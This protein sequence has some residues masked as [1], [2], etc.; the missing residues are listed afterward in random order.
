MGPVNV[1]LARRAWGRVLRT[2]PRLAAFVGRWLLRIG[3]PIA[4]AAALLTLFPYHAS[5]GGVQF[6]V[7]GSLIVNPG[8]SAD[9]TVGNW[10]F[11]QVDFLPVG[12]HVQ[13]VDL[14]L[15]TMSSAASADPAAYAEQLRHELS[16][17]VPAITAWLVAELMLGILLGL[18]AAAA[19]NLAIRQWRGQPR[20]AHELR[21]R[22]RQL[23]V[24]GLVLLVLVGVGAATYNPHWA[25]RS[26]LSG[27][28]AALQLFPGDLR[29]YYAQRTKALDVFDAIAV[30][31]SNLEQRVAIGTTP[32]TAYSIMFISDMH[33]ASNYPMVMRYAESFDVD[34]IINT[35]D[36]SEF[37]T[38]A[39]LTTAY[40]NQLRAVTAETPMIWL[41][42]NH[43]S[44]AT[45]AVMRTIPGVTVLGRKVAAADSYHV[46]AQV[47]DAYGLTVAAVPDPRVYGGPGAYGAADSPDVLPLERRAIDEALASVAPDLKLDI[48]ATHEPVAAAEA[49]KVLPGQIRQTNAGHA[50][51]QNKDSDLQGG[52]SINLVEGSIG[53]GGLDN[54]GR[55][56]PAPPVEF[57]IES[58]AA[59]C[60]FTKI[61]RFQITGIAPTSPEDTTEGLLPQVT[62]STHYFQPQ[63]V[64]TGRTCS[65]SQGLSGVRD[66]ATPPASG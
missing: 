22:T 11:P 21:H 13:P 24:A 62:A 1:D 16:K 54:L 25:R 49:A 40:L 23:G 31:Q 15:V 48:F 37:G 20:R 7:H 9:T 45:V 6:R 4:F 64:A 30:I 29:A 27:T 5:A 63:D 39:E 43:D 35:G 53:A 32:D 47:M 34:L 59:D 42:G 55:H 17:Q 66:L 33:L 52:G 46:D 3:L 51:A 56:V 8:F 14:D 57:S 28:L 38:R 60:Q 12:V 10:V 61:E 65:T 18:G 26:H 41:A 36:E 44:P 19:I 2:A 58:V 50:H